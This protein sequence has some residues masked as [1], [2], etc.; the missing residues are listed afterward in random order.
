MYC[1][2]CGT[3]VPDD[4]SFCV[5]CGTR[6]RKDDANAATA[7]PKE[8][9]VAGVAEITSGIDET[10]SIG[11]VDGA[12]IIEDKPIKE[13][14]KQRRPLPTKTR[15]MIFTAVA[16]L[17]L[18]VGFGSPAI[19]VLTHEDSILS[20]KLDTTSLEEE[21]SKESNVS[22]SSKGT[23]SASSSNKKG[24]SSSSSRSSSSAS[25]KSATS[26]S[27]SSSKGAAAGDGGYMLPEVASRIYTTE[28]LD[29]FS[30]YELYLARNEIFARYGRGF[31]NADL[32]DHFSSKDWY[33]QRYSPAEF[34]AMP[35]PLNSYEKEN[36]DAIRALEAQRNSQYAA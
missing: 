27:S 19:T 21:S 10:P 7:E 20:G 24:S 17:A 29:A 33:T 22:S 9:S 8:I 35:S 31:K 36:L 3:Q 16:V 11:D 25:S 18:A 32:V 28:E 26:S 1:H 30:D 2:N 5:Q 12:E 15:W 23:D 6:A 14:G 4:A 13:Q 34:D